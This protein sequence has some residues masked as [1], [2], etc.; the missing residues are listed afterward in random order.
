MTALSGKK[1]HLIIMSNGLIAADGTPGEVFSDVELMEREGL[2]VPETTKL[3][4][5]LNEQ[6]FSLPLDALTPEAC[7]A[8]IVGGKTEIDRE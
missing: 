6:G 3:M 5:E 8:A 1:A 7:A 4:H 2:A